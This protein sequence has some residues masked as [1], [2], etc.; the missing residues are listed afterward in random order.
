VHAAMLSN[1]RG[2]VNVRGRRDA[3]GVLLEADADIGVPVD[4]SRLPGRVGSLEPTHRGAKK[5]RMS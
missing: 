2:G 1:G 5:G 4:D 3:A